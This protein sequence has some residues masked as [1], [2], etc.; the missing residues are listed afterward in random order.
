MSLMVQALTSHND[1][2]IA[3]LLEDI[4]RSSSNGMMHESVWMDD[5]YSY[6]NPSFAWA[7]S[8]LGELLLYLNATRPHHAPP[9]LLL[10]VRSAALP[11]PS[12][13]ARERPWQYA[14]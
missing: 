7:N 10:V 8:L 1:S 4:A 6:T 5:L 12:Q 2:E 14:S 11:G 13:S 9:P 3:G